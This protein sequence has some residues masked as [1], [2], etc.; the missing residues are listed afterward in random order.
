MKKS[1]VYFFIFVFIVFLS[2]MISAVEINA[3]S[4]SYE[5]I[6]SAI[7]LAEDGDMVLVPEGECVWTSNVIIPETKGI[8]L[9]GAG[10]SNTLITLNGGYLYLRTNPTNSPV[11]VSGFSFIGTSSDTGIKINDGENGS[12]NWRIDHCIFSR[13]SSNGA[14]IFVDGWT[15]GLIDNCNFSNWRALFVQHRHIGENFDTSGRYGTYS[16]TQPITIGGSDAVY[17]ENCTF[18][19]S[20]GG[21]FNDHRYGARL[22]VRYNNLSNAVI[23]S[24]S[25]C[26]N[27]G[28]NSRWF[29]VY[30]NILDGEVSPRTHPYFLAIWH[31]SVNGVVFNNSIV[32]YYRAVQ[33]DYE[34]ACRD[35]CI[36]VWINY[37]NPVDQY[38]GLDQIGVGQDSGLGNSQATDE[39]KFWAW[40]NI[41]NDLPVNASARNT[42]ENSLNLIQEGRD[43]FHYAPLNYIPY[44]YPHPL[45]VAPFG[46]TIC[47]EGEITEECWCEGMKT[48]GYCYN[49]YYF[50]EEGERIEPPPEIP[51]IDIVTLQNMLSAY[52]QYKTNEVSLIYFLDKLRNWIVFW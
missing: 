12:K 10:A 26:T 48:I 25:G 39:A 27:G 32:N 11:R 42:C 30:E 16:W 6:Q 46:T 34:M 13:E 22:V 31:R 51:T 5:H 14:A 8:S 20:D 21:Q 4:C 17:V 50:T 28:R 18:Y 40:S 41:L 43:Y 37:G 47:N 9:I 52:Q 3:V 44:I 29:E 23:S 19:R 35:N 15:W 45:S 1:L 49:G 33:F 36:G 24:H 7:N 38:P 2:S